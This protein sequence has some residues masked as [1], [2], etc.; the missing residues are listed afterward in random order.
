MIASI[1][2]H[3]S[4]TNLVNTLGKSH[5]QYSIFSGA[6]HFFLSRTKEPDASDDYNPY[7]QYPLV[8]KD[9]LKKITND[10][11]K[12]DCAYASYAYHSD[13]SNPTIHSLSDLTEP[14]QLNTLL[15]RRRPHGSP[16]DTLS[17]KAGDDAMLIS[18][19]V[20]AIADG[21][22]GWETKDTNCSSGIWSRSMVETLSRLM[23]EY[24]F[25]HAPHHLNKRDIDEILDDSFLHTSHL[26]DLQGLS[27]S[28][29]L[30]LSMLSG[31]Y[32][33]MISIGDSKLYII[34]DGDII[35]TN[36]EQMIS[37]LCPQ[38]IGTQ[39]L[40]QLPSE[41]AWVDSMKLKEGDIIVMC[42][43]GISD[44][45]YE[46]EIVHYLDESLN[47]KKDS[48]KKA[49]N[50][51]LVKAK[52]VAFDDYA[53]TPYNEKVN[54]LPAAKYGHNASTGGKLD[55]MSICIARVVNNTK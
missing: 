33:K 55:D 7:I 24:K 44:N 12:L 35:E 52:E 38:Q 4:F 43:D 49:A 47:L 36:K 20:M 41:M 39:T 46:W 19:T 5:R 34:R 14:T 27:G 6:R 11:Y 31:E 53:Y 42:S 40:G 22:T 8:T 15:P 51:I 45:L 10:K 23:T 17:I 16:A 1:S 18:P 30:I 50:N 32:L 26:M 9:Q 21:V 25:N 48:L 29:T 37:D 3:R 54:A 13:G 2:R 28:S